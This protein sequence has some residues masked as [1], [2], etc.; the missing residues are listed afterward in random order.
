MIIPLSTHTHTLSFFTCFKTF[1]KISKAQNTNFK[2]APSL[3]ARN[4]HLAQIT[5]WVICT[6]TTTLWHIRSTDAHT[7]RHTHATHERLL[8][9]SATS[10]IPIG[11]ESVCKKLARPDRGFCV[12]GPSHTNHSRGSGISRSQYTRIRKSV[13]RGSARELY[14][15]FR[16]CYQWQP[17]QKRL[18]ASRTYHHHRDNGSRRSSFNASQ[19]GAH[20]D[21]CRR[22]FAFYFDA[23]LL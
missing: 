11:T 17:K 4:P 19:C 9:A 7:H 10:V 12:G 15:R 8:V 3:T 5:L 20:D 14:R 6:L 2:T 21:S 23:L 1:F 16:N 13:P 22:G 18:R